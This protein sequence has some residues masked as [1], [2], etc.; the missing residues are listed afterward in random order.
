MTR[1]LK[2]VLEFGS[3]SMT[4][5]CTLLL[6]LGVHFLGV[7]GTCWIKLTLWRLNC[8]RIDFNR[9]T[10]DAEKMTYT[11]KAV[12]EVIRR[13]NCTFLQICPGSELISAI[14][15][16]QCLEHGQ[17]NY[18]FGSRGNW[19]RPNGATKLHKWLSSELIK[20]DFPR[21]QYTCTYTVN[22]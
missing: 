18:I 16:F 5:T 3:L 11:K 20:Q 2:L 21:R 8:I 15:N 10:V 7:M 17:H 19:F 4:L 22:S 1:T 6:V 12:R 14:C 9:I 13:K